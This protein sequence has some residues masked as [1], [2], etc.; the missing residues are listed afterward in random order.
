M[1]SLT[2]FSIKTVLIFSQLQKDFALT[3]QVEKP[4]FSHTT[5]Q[6]IPT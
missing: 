2:P 1:Y 6:R 5:M 3:G 4:A